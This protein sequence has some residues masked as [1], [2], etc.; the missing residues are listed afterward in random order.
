MDAGSSD[1]QAPAQA[2]PE[3]LPPAKR[4]HGGNVMI[5]GWT[6]LIFGLIA[7]FIS[8]A[9]DPQYRDGSGI[10]LDRMRQKALFF[11]GAAAALSAGTLLLLAGYIVRA[12]WFLPGDSERPTP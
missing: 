2:H 5:A 10:D 6:L 4:P 11:W 3:S 12:I 9:M 8:G 7:A 1:T